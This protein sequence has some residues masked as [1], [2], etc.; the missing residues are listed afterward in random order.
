VAVVTGARHVLADVVEQRGVLE[1]LARF[2]AE[3]VE[4]DRPVEQRDREGRDAA[5]MSLVPAGLPAG[6]RTSR[7]GRAAG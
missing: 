2:A 7:Q 5:G 4:L 1:Q 6:R 3:T